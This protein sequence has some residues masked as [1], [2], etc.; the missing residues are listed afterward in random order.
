MDEQN[1]KR[2]EGKN[3]ISFNLSHCK[4]D[5]CV[6]VYIRLKYNLIHPFNNPQIITWQL[7]IID[8]FVK[9]R[10]HVKTKG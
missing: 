9:N 7:E 6:I 5:I 1:W 3:H 10:K 8:L 4:R 2:R